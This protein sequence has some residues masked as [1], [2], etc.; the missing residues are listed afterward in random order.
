MT[1]DR[2]AMLLRTIDEPVE[3][4][5]AFLDSSF[6]TLAGELGLRSRPRARRRRGAIWWLAAAVLLAAVLL[7]SRIGAAHGSLALLHI[8][9]AIITAGFG[10]ALV[11]HGSLAEV[12]LSVTVVSA[13]LGIGFCALPVLILEHVDRSQTAAVNGLNA[14]ARVIGSVLASALVTAVMASGIVTAAGQDAPAEWTFLVS[15]AIGMAPAL[16][17]GGI[18]W[19]SRRRA[20]HALAPSCCQRRPVYKLD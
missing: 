3:P 7:A 10:L 18:A 5:L 19:R 17:V 13:G 16:A 15:Y 12:V 6:E 14:L 2:L 8:S 11:W 1:E 9:A 20:P 4:S